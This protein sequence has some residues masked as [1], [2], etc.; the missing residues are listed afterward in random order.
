LDLSVKQ[1]AG[2]VLVYLYGTS[3]G[4]RAF[5]AALNDIVE[6]IRSADPGTVNVT[7]RTIANLAHSEN[8]GATVV[9][10]A[11]LLKLAALSTIFRRT[12]S[13]GIFQSVTIALIE[14]IV[15]EWGNI[16]RDLEAGDTIRSCSLGVIIDSAENPTDASVCSASLI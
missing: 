16:H 8:P 12:P 5:R 9:E 15:E 7:C 1:E 2:S 10:N 4:F 14:A 13:T 6:E 11:L 3:M